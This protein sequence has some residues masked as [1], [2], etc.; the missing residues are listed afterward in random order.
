VNKISSFWSFTLVD[1]LADRIGRAEIAGIEAFFR[2]LAQK[3]S[4]GE[5]LILNAFTSSALAE[6]HATTILT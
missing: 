5:E 2:N 1:M 3:A 4:K 6:T